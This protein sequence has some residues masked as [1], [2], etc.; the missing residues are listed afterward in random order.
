MIT[1]IRYLE[2]FKHEIQ[3]KIEGVY[4]CSTV[5]TNKP[6][7]TTTRSKISFRFIDICV[8]KL[9]YYEYSDFKTYELH[10]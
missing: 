4:Y 3:I 1:S 9:L 8:Y 2:L 10:V 5:K 6:K 7:P